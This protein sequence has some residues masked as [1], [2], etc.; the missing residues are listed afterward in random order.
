MVNYFEQ[1]NW[2][3]LKVN[4]SKKYKDESFTGIKENINL[5]DNSCHRKSYVGGIDHGYSVLYSFKD[6]KL[7]LAIYIY[8][9][10]WS[11]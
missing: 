7:Y 3:N 4:G 2:E 9:Y 11:N 6:C 1:E 8:I 10:L 5:E